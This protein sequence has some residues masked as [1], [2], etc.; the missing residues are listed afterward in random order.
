VF[1]TTDTY[2]NNSVTATL[3][4]EVNGVSVNISGANLIA[5]NIS[6]EE[7]VYWTPVTYYDVEDIKNTDKQSIRALNKEYGTTAALQ[8]KRLLSK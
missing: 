3:S 5:K 6:D 2:S 1:G 8:L 7:F 4:G